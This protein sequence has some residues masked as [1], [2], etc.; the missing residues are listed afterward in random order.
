MRDRNS[1]FENFC[2]GGEIFPKEKV[3][4]NTYENE[5]RTPSQSRCN[6]H[7]VVFGYRASHARGT[8]TVINTDNS[9]VDYSARHSSS[10][11]T[12]GTHR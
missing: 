9:G 10:A 8:I 6:R 4:A 7:S 5:N 12:A 2:N 3:K 11:A 1:G